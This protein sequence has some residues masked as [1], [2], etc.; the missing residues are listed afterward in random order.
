MNIN[1]NFVIFT[2][3][4]NSNKQYVLSKQSENIEFLHKTLDFFWVENINQKIIEYLKGY[5]YVSDFSLIPQLIT[6]H[7]PSIS[8]DTDTLNVVYGFIV[9]F[10]QSINDCYWVPLDYIT[11]HKY[12]NLLLEVIQKLQ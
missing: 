3:E 1:L 7:S 12:S 6:L 2:T 5:V 11:P 10:T 4:S 9:P 8:T